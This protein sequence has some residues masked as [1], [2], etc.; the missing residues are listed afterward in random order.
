MCQATYPAVEPADRSLSLRCNITGPSTPPL[1]RSDSPRQ[2]TEL[3]CTPSQSITP[4]NHQSPQTDRG[5]S[6]RTCRTQP[7]AVAVGF[8]PLLSPCDLDNYAPRARVT[9]ASHL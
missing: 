6:K 1:L 8:E 5:I 3:E 4:D 7:V 9:A 2:V